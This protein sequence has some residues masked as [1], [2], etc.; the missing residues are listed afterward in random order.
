MES[1]LEAWGEMVALKA[2]FVDRLAELPGE[3]VRTPLGAD[4]WS[5]AQVVDHVVRVERLM[6]VALARA[7]SPMPPE[8]PETQALREGWQAKVRRG[9][10]FEVPDPSAEPDPDPDVAVILEAWDKLRAKLGAR[11]TGGQ[12]AGPD[13]LAVV[14]PLA[15]PLNSDDTLRFLALHLEYHRLRTSALMG[16][17]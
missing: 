8:T 16:G 3:S 6:G 9:E 14:H 2:W 17:A 1:A 4:E 11:V 10:R 12:L 13:V 7:G 5:L 15:G